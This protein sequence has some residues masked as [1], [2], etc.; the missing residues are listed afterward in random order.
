MKTSNKLF[1]AAV[2]LV[3]GSLA[4]YDAAL[5]AE[6]GTGHFRDPLRNYQALGLRNFDRI[7]VP[8]AGRLHVKIERGPFAVH[9]NKD[10]AEYVHVTQQN[11]QLAVA[12]DYPKEWKW[13]GQKD[14][15]RITCPQL[16]ALS[17]KGTYTVAGQPQHDKL[18][19]GGEVEIK[20]FR[21]DSLALQLDQST[22]VLLTG[23]LLRQLRATTGQRPG[24]EPSLTIGAD[25]HIQAADLTIGS[26]GHLD[27]ATA[28]SNLRHR[29]SDSATVAFSGAAARSLSATR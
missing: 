21:Q 10:A 28:I 22:H 17:A 13:L 5:H 24:T 20:G 1:V 29:F 14:A 3:L 23:N 15:L 4:T 7:S 12:L 25:N 18:E 6:Y 11:G 16:A 2:A 9:L 8:A 26:R 19:G 27:L